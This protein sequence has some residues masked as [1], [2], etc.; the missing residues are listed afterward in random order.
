MSKLRDYGLLLLLIMS[1]MAVQTKQYVLMFRLS[2][3]PPVYI[4]WRKRRLFSLELK[5]ATLWV[6]ESFPNVIRNPANREILLH[7]TC[8]HCCPHTPH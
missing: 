4:L 2:Q 8:S 6:T 5:I 7:S 3:L 1:V